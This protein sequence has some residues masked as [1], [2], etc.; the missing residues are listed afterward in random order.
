MFLS[1]EKLKRILVEPRHVSAEGFEEALRISRLDESTIEEALVK[2]GLIKDENLGR[3]IADESGYDYINLKKQ[4]IDEISG[5]ML[6]Y[7]PEVVAQ[8]QK[9]I[10]F[11]ENSEEIK[12]ATSDPGNYTFLK[13]LEQKASKKV[14]VHYATPFDMEQAL[15]KYKGNL[16]TR[17]TELIEKMRKKKGEGAEE[18]V[19]QF[20]NSIVDYAESNTASDIHIEPQS[21]S[22]I[23]R[24]RVDG[25]L[26]KVAEYPKKL[27]DRITSR[28]KIM[29]RLRTDEKEATQDG[30]F[31]FELTNGGKIDMRVSVMPTTEGENIVMRL[32]MQEGNRFSIDELGLLDKDLKRVKK[33]ARKPYG[34]IVVVGPTGSGKSTTL[35]SVLQML[36]NPEVNIM[37]VEDPTEYNVEGVQQ[38]QVNPEKGV[39]FLEGLRAIVRQDPDVIMVGEIRDE[40]TVDM[41]L[42]SAMTGHLVLTT[43]HAND[44]ATTFPR[45][46]EMNAEPFLVSSSVN[47]IIAQRLVR[48]ICNKCKRSH[49]LSDEELELLSEV[50]GLPETVKKI[51]GEEDLSKIRFYKGNGCKVCEG[52]GYSG[53]T[54]I[55]EVLEIS[56]KIKSLVSNKKTSDLIKKQAMKEGMTTMVQDGVMKA[57]MG[58]TTLEEIS[59]A[60]KA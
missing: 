5:K 26:H 47:V 48:T 58:E 60:A 40:E 35:Y 36:S 51:S 1:E 13:T 30:R 31:E 37:T 38:T 18:S 50:E 20:V 21:D 24:F 41:A 17:L 56:E 55:F 23:I 49:F 15:K 9:A 43:M 28:L 4:N 33:A 22:G 7:I 34:M 2:K 45:F 25:I 29:A 52:S 54:A 16:S 6:N 46:L 59:K 57:L 10:V 53:R 27:H 14:N 32:L 8:S 11:D 3:I 42:N 12:V 39:T 44:A 19:V